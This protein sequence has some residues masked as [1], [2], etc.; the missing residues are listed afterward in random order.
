MR[1][2]ENLVYRF[3]VIA[4]GSITDKNLG[5][6]KNEIYTNEFHGKAIVGSFK[7]VRDQLI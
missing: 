4:A 5:L 1:S 2:V 3:R 7:K 6:L